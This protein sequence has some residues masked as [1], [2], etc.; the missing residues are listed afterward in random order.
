MSN[1]LTCKICGKIFNDCCDCVCCECGNVWCSNKCADEDGFNESHCK[2]GFDID[3]NECDKSCSCCDNLILGS[4]KYCRKEDF[5]DE[6]LLNYAIE[7][8]EIDREKLI[9]KYKNNNQGE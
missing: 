1:H 7:L 4:C 8:L 9:E 6:I 5:S 3:N 2:L